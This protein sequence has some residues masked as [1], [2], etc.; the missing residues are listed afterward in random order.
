MVCRV[1]M[2]SQCDCQVSTVY[3]ASFEQPDQ[4][5][6]LPSAGSQVSDR[7]KHVLRALGRLLCNYLF[8]KFVDESAKLHVFFWH[9]SP[10][11]FSFLCH[12]EVA[13]TYLAW[14]YPHSLCSL[15]TWC[16]CTQYEFVHCIY[17]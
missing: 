12:E 11:L 13:L 14:L 10:F 3:T 8:R 1:D 16:F 6:A 7:D 5:F 2:D 4:G 17:V 15:H 9:F